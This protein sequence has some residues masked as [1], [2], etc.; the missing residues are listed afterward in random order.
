MGSVIGV[1]VGD[2]NPSAT[3]LYKFVYI[4]EYYIFPFL[5]VISFVVSLI[6]GIKG[7]SFR[8]KYYFPTVMFIINI[9]MVSYVFL[10]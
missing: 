9:I 6:F 8:P 4:N 1:S 5:A 10:N 2:P 3:I 7:L